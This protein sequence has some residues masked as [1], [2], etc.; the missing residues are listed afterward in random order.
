MLSSPD[1]PDKLK[2]TDFVVI[3][4]VILLPLK[5]CRGQS[6]VDNCIQNMSIQPASSTTPNYYFVPLSELQLVDQNNIVR[7]FVELF[8]ELKVSISDINILGPNPDIA[9]I[10]TSKSYCR[11]MMNNIGLDKYN[12]DYIMYYKDIYDCFIDEKF[13]NTVIKA[14]GL[15]GGKG[16]FVYGDHFNNDEEAMAIISE[17]YK[18]HNLFIIILNNFPKK[19]NFKLIYM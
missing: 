13:V 17:I 19:A 2:K 11:T 9:R 12:P 18:N 5:S 16:V 4:N 7:Q 1:I 10:E 8:P 14:D 3:K 6:V 15:A